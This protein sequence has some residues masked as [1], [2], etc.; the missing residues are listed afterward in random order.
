MTKKSTL[1]DCDTDGF[2]ANLFHKGGEKAENKRLMSTFSTQGDAA[3]A[4]LRGGNIMKAIRSAVVSATGEKEADLTFELRHCSVAADGATEATVVV[5]VKKTGR[6]HTFRVAADKRGKTVSVR[7]EG[8]HV[9]MQ[10][11]F[12]GA[13]AQKNKSDVKKWVW[14]GIAVAVAVAIVIAVSVVVA[15]KVK[16]AKEQGKNAVMQAAAAAIK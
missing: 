2:C 16:A 1:E 13:T 11:G 9:V 10:E 14:V 5:P 8:V 12:G 6:V 4:P 7:H 15:K 3:C